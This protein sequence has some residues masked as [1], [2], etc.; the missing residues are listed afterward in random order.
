[1][2]LRAQLLAFGLLTLVLPWAGYR[3]VQE[4]EAALRSGLE[5]AMLASAQTVAAALDEQAP[6][7]ARRGGGGARGETLYAAPLPAEPELD[8]FRTDWSTPD[9]AALTM[10]GGHRLWVGAHDRHAYVFLAALDSEIVYEGLPGESP[11]G[12]RL[13][14]AVESEAG[15]RGT[16]LLGTRGP[17]P[18]RARRTS[19][20]RFAPTD[21]YE[22]RI[23]SFW[24]ETPEGFAVE[25]R[26]PLSLAGSA[27]GIGL[28]DVDAADGTAR[29]SSVD[30]TWDTERGA[31]GPLVRQ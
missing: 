16:F 15:V 26:I 20:P 13:I 23:Q 6:L 1:M 22:D 7:I 19:A 9:E 18:F 3:F 24:Q 10:P 28:I 14:V 4:M 25:I 27:L 17:G 31:P 29:V 12:D 2:S 5:Q 30:A 11:Y 21:V 8:G